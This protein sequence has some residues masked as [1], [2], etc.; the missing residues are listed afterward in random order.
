MRTG[1]TARIP[2]VSLAL[3]LAI[4]LSLSLVL[5]L[6]LVLSLYFSP[7]LSL[8]ISLT[9]PLFCS[10][11]LSLALSLSPSLSRTWL[12]Q[13][14][15]AHRRHGVFGRHRVSHNT[16]LY[17]FLSRKYISLSLPL[18]HTYLVTYPSLSLS[19]S[20]TWFNRVAHRRQGIRGLRGVYGRH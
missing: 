10:L 20:R 16:P 1:G 2:T 7:S 17:L 14:R 13:N 15:A 6:A 19:F 5:F 9:L 12:E 8:S 18:A 4:S 3:S 11:S